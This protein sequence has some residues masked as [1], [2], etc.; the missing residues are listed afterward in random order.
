MVIGEFAGVLHGS[1]L[2]TRDLDLCTMVTPESIEKLRHALADFNPKHRMSPKRVSFLTIPENPSGWNNI[3]L[4]TDLGVVD[5]INQVTGVGDF[6]RLAEKAETVELFGHPCKVISL[7]DL[8]T[9]K[10][11]MGRPKD[12]AMIVELNT[13]KGVRSGVRS[14]DKK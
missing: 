6:K 11:A 14:K 13:I 3:Y 4:E 5:F 2:V 7:E 8:V 9:A 10:M 12:L 1:T